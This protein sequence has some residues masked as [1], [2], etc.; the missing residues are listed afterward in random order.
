[1]S[2]YK[3]KSATINKYATIHK[4]A[5]IHK[6][7]TH[8]LTNILATY[9]FISGEKLAPGALSNKLGTIVEDIIFP[10]TRPVLESYFKCKITY[11]S[12]NIEKVKGKLGGEFDIIATSDEFKT[13][14]IIE[15]K[16]S[17]R[18]DYVNEFKE[19]S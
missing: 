8:N 9:I 15:V 1:V 10:A 4:S 11:I 17:P 3:D 19:K 16:S 14:F 5:K 13:V 12:T 18:I 7:A 6:V 2:T